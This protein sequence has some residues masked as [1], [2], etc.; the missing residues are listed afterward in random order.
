MN[1]LT[2]IKNNSY[3]LNTYVKIGLYLRSGKGILIDSSSD[4]DS[5]KKVQKELM[6]K[7]IEPHAI[8]NTHYHADHI[9]GNRF[10]QDKYGLLCYALKNDLPFLSNSL[11]EIESFYGATPPKLFETKVFMAEESAAEDVNNFDCGEDLMLTE[12]KG[13]S[14]QLLLV[15]TK[16]GV[17][18]AS[19]SLMPQEILNKYKIVFVHDVEEYLKSFD[20][21]TELDA[22]FF[23]LAHH[24]LVNALEFKALIE[25]NR[26]H[27]LEM[28]DRIKNYIS[29]PIVFDDLI[30]KVFDDLGLSLN[31][32]Q[33][34]LSGSTVKAYLSYLYNRS[35]ADIEVSDNKLYWRSK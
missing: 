25:F 19:D 9:G 29:E 11:L 6:S 22:E 34:L 20:V 21:L 13:H 24:G 35:E 31:P 2:L 8:I 32:A 17:C 5:A 23:L 16:D 27:T 3:Y 4:R 12:I 18:Y 28:V 7:G 30:K 1:E 33:Y 10:F 14:N 26:R 15:T